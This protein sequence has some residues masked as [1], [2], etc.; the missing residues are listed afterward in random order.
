MLNI[1]GTG[2][3]VNAKQLSEFLS[4]WSGVALLVEAREQ[5]GEKN[6][7]KKRR[8]EMVQLLELPLVGCLLVG[9]ALYACYYQFKWQQ[10][11]GL[12][13]VI[14][15]L[16]LTGVAV[17]GLL[18]WYQV[19]KANPLLQ[20]ICGV[21][22]QTGCKAIL[23]SKQAK[24]FNLVSWSEIG[25]F[26]FAGGLISLLLSGTNAAP[27][28]QVLVW[29]N[30]LALPYTF[31][32]IYY[33]WKVAKQWCPLCLAVQALL[34][35]EFLSAILISPSL[36]IQNS[37]FNI[38]N[39]FPSIQHST[40]IIF[41]SFL[42]P[43]SAWYLLQPLLL[44]T[45]EAKRQKRELL[46]FKYDTR[47]FDAL[48][49]KQKQVTVSPDGLGQTIGNPHAANTIIKVCNPY[50]GPCARAHPQL[51]ELLDANPDLKV[52]I[53]FTATNN[54]NDRGSKPVKH[55][56]AI[57]AGNNEMHTRKALDAWYLSEKK[58]YEVF[59]AKYPMNGEL[60]M[61]DNKVEA[62][63]KWCKETGIEF[64]PTFFVNGFQLPNVYNVGDLKYF[65]SE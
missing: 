51:H 12:Y 43:L 52:Q 41:F 63:N 5:G 65:L 1:K 23:G 31:F 18:L 19:D 36:I 64:T 11:T 24:L 26:Y 62:M 37:A 61:Q 42:L 48:L 28:L 27:I 47:I 50:C 17:T 32:S 30:V 10:L 54:E 22:S 53:L 15:F 39:A 38:Q 14:L 9:I 49:A 16:K 8:M 7:L 25:F 45:Q 2:V 21:G 55:L 6:Y 59:A 60:R 3:G 33:Q 4:D 57:T 44:Q 29:L 13:P 20:Q 35:L 34:I 58:E 40:F 46:R 56:L